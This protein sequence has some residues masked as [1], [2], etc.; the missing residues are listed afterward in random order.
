MLMK[1]S[2][3]SLRMQNRGI[4]LSALRR[5]GAVSHTEIS[6]WSGLSSATISAITTE[7]EKENVLQRVEQ[8]PASGRGRPRVKLRQNPEAAYIATVRI[9]SETLQ[10]SLIDYSGVMKDRF[11]EKRPPEE[12]GVDEFCTRFKAGLKRLAER[13]KLNHDRILTISIATKGLVTRGKPEL[14]WSPVFEDQTIDFEALL[15]KDWSG[16]IRLTND[17]QFAAQ[18]VMRKIAADPSAQE[19]KQIAVLSLNHSIGLGIATQEPDGRITAFAPPFGHMMHISNG[20]VCRCGSHGCIEAYAGYYGIL[21]TAFE[22]DKNTIPAKF[23]PSAEI[24]KIAVR[25][26]QGDRMSEYAFRMAGEAIGLGI[27]RLLTLLGPMPIAITG[28]GISFYDLMQEAILNGIKNNLQIRREKMP[29]I[30]LHPDESELIFY[31][32]AQSCLSDLDNNTISDRT[33]IYWKQT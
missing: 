13:A 18:A 17:T 11:E 2:T 6:E 19:R 33:A 5:L 15:S 10:Y 14:N 3:E 21:R 29:E 28:A 25:A 31:G 30:S 12:T 9:T 20:P 4:V 22:V 32:N 24:E 8:A 16:Q 7:L 27:G 23:I 26:R 1:A